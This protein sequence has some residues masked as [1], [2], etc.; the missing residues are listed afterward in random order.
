MWQKNCEQE[1]WR[2]RKN[3]VRKQKTRKWQ[4]KDSEDCAKKV[5]RSK[6]EVL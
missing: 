5:L 3:D 1:K 4:K 2:Q 6:S